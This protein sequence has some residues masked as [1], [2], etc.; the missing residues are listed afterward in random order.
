[1][2][3]DRPSNWPAPGQPV[4]SA[5]T[6]RNHPGG[7]GEI[8]H[9]DRSSG[10]DYV[11]VGAAQSQEACHITFDRLRAVVERLTAAAQVRRGLSRQSVNDISTTLYRIPMPAL[12]TM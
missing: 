8:V 5:A 12:A 3:E 2:I 7:R 1:V 11:P 10:V 9:N 4:R 6:A